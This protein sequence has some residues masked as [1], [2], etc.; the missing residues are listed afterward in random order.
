MLV[1]VVD[2]VDGAVVDFD[3]LEP[4]SDELEPESDEPEPDEPELLRE[5]VR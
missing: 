5:S 2:G 4:E 1:E 3:S